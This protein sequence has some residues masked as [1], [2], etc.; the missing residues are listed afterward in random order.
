MLNKAIYPPQVRKQREENLTFS[1]NEC[2]G[3]NQGGDF[4]MEQKIKRQ[5]MMAPKG[6]VDKA[7]WQRISRCVDTFDKI[8]DNVSNLLSLKDD[9]RSGNILLSEEITEWR[10]FLR[11]SKFLDKTES[12]QIFNIFGE[13][14]SDSLIN[15]SERLRE[16]RLEYWRQHLNGLKLS[17]I[18][19]ELLQTYAEKDVD[20]YSDD[21]LL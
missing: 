18:N 5:K 4:L 6:N 2:H 9:P 19:Y 16:K 21:E 10:A 14:M 3:R 7:T 1:I 13:P 8:Y 20:E 12:S 17:K 15:L 11:H